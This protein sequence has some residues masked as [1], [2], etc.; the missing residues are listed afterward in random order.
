MDEKV[1]HLIINLNNLRADIQMTAVSTKAMMKEPALA[2]D[3]HISKCDKGEA[4]ANLMIAF[5]HLE[6]A[7]MRLGKAIQAADGGTSIY[8]KRR[9]TIEELEA[10]LQDK[11]TYKVNLNPD[12]SISAQRVPDPIPLKDIPTCE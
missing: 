12:G 3:V 11:G 7:R 1:T 9:P 8:D 4:R 5:R 10:I 2:D 6:D